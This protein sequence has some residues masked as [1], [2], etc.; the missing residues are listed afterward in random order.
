MQ[1]VVTAYKDPGTDGVKQVQSTGLHIAGD[2]F[3]VLK[4]DERSIYGK[5]VSFFFFFLGFLLA[6]FLVAFPLPFFYP[7]GKEEDEK[8]G[9][10]VFSSHLVSFPFFLKKKRKNPKRRKKKINEAAGRANFSPLLAKI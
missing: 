8:A 1:E 4:A 7:I 2:R 3:V 10:K 9:T 5:K 6:L